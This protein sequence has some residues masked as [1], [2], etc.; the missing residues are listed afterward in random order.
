MKDQN[1]IRTLQ[2]ENAGKIDS[3]KKQEPSAA[4]MK[5]ETPYTIYIAEIYQFIKESNAIFG[6]DADERY[7]QTCRR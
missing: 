4:D 7:S 3:K 5:D 1:G 6:C 2:K